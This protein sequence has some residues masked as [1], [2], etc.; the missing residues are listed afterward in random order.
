MK[1]TVMGR[2]CGTRERDEKYMNFGENMKERANLED[3]NI[4]RKTILKWILQ[5]H[6][7]RS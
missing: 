2:A 3:I 6:D 7:R 5:K 4:D 1:E